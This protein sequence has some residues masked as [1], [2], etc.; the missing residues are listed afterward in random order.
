[1]LIK[2]ITLPVSFAVPLIVT[3]IFVGSY[4]HLY[5]IGDLIV[6]MGA[7]ALGYYA[8][9]KQHY[10]IG[11]FL[12]GFILGGQTER[13]Y[14]ITM[15]TY[16]P[17]FLLRPISFVLLIIF[18]IALVYPLLAHVYKK[19]DSSLL[20]VK[21]EE[22]LPSRSE[23]LIV[24]SSM[25]VFSALI[26]VMTFTS[27]RNPVAT[28]FPL[29]VTIPT[30]AL[31]LV[32]LIKELEDK[33]EDRSLVNRAEIWREMAL[34]LWFIFFT[35]LIWLLNFVVA[36]PVFTYLLTKFYFR[37]TQR[38]AIITAAISSATIY[39]IFFRMAQ[40]FALGRGVLISF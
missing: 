22:S 1:L 36:V 34:F 40:M 24:I 8:W 12:L 39:V 2:S 6:T 31:G 32:Q 30:L 4:S 14:R 33:R 28:K 20:A 3:L 13:N 10:P 7:G 35:A 5:E 29:L 9:R 19:K 21:K 25:V 15:S 26:L 38:L 17:S 11:P 16:G 27:V 37:G 23:G 18:V